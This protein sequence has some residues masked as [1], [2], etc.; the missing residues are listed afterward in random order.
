MRSLDKGT[1]LVR[2]V[3][4]DSYAIAIERNSINCTFGTITIEII[5]FY[6]QMNAREQ[7]CN[8]KSVCLGLVMK[9]IVRNRMYLNKN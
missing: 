5:P 9:H 6:H 7:I 8:T 3:I 2:S 4:H 1:F